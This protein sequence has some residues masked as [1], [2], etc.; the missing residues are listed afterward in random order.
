M[1]KTILYEENNSGNNYVYVWQN[2]AYKVCP[3][4]IQLF[5]LNRKSILPMAVV[6]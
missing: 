4:M 3:G 5:N 2:H 6:P 1:L